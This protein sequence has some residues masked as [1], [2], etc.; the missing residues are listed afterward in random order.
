MSQR[1]KHI[2]QLHKPA[3]RVA[4][5][6]VRNI[7]K[8]MLKA[9]RIWLN[10]A[11][12]PSGDQQDSEALHNF[13]VEIRRLRVW[14]QQTRDLIRNKT[15]A[16]M[17][18]KNWAQGSN[19][20]RDLEVML[21]LLQQA[22]TEIDHG[23]P[24]IPLVQDSTKLEELF[25]QHPLT[26]K[27]RTRISVQREGKASFANWL[28]DRLSIELEKT[29]PLFKDEDETLHKA[30]IH[31]KHMRYLIEPIASL[32]HVATH[33]ALTQLKAMQT[34]LG[35]LHDL[36]VLRQRLS[37]VLC[38][39]LNERLSDLI[40]RPGIPTRGIQEALSATRK[41]FTVC[42]GWQANQYEAAMNDWHSSS[43]QTCRQMEN[44]LNS[45]IN[46]LRNA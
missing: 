44:A 22:N 40:K 24:S 14:L 39:Q 32:R 12:N 8:N 37:D 2:K 10:Q 33:P 1:I 6:I 43:Q 7:R 3:D 29:L 36:F 31:I 23:L 28:A 30:R 42:L 41:Q 45:L 19:A 13:R 17:Q 46:E 27:P 21:G 20:G 34:R 25:S 18:L 9:R 38:D 5:V 26:L 35:N 4:R 15:K 11:A 16:R